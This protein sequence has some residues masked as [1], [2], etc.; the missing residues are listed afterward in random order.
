M[1][2]KRA[3]VYFLSGIIESGL[4]HRN[5]PQFARRFHFPVT[6]LEEVAR[7]PKEIDKEQIRKFR[8]KASPTNQYYLS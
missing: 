4:Q 8:Q 6:G 1:G 7:R 2:G 3:S 5:S